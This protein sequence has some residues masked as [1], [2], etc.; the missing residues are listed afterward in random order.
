MQSIAAVCCGAFLAASSQQDWVSACYRARPKRCRWPSKKIKPWLRDRRSGPFANR[1]TIIIG[2][3]VVHAGF[4]RGTAAAAYAAG[5]EHSSAM[6]Q[7]RS[8]I[9][10]EFHGHN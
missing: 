5:G 3:V 2:A 9:Q 6:R 7:G 10:E 4:A 1:V 8:E